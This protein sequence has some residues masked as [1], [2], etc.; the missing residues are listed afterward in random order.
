MIKRCLYI[1]T[2]L[3]LASCASLRH[4][5][6][7][8]PKDVESKN[9][10]KEISTEKQPE[11]KEI[12]IVAPSVSKAELEAKPEVP[13]KPETKK[14]PTKKTRK[15]EV[16]APP[17]ELKKIA[18]PFSVGEIFKMDLYFIGIKAAT[19]T[20]E[21]KPF[22]EINGKKM[23]HFTGIAETSSLMAL[24]YKVYNVIDTYVDYDTFVPVKMTLTM[25]ESK[26]NVSMVLNYDHKD[27]KS[28]FW[29][30]R[31]DKDKNITEINRVDD[32]TPMAQDMFS[33]LYYVRMLPLKV[34]E[35]YKF[36]IHDNGK[37]WTLIIDVVKEEK[38]WTRL[39]AVDTLLLHPTAERD[40]E[41]FTKGSMY[42]WVTNDEKKIPVKFEAE[43]RIGSMKG[44]IKD[45]IKGQE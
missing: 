34:G 17:Q 32:L 14:G 22:V 2:L 41:K 27:G 11:L 8:V 24:I 33:S 45:Y 25:D 30:K 7:A 20:V 36:V 12:T 23:F 18:A 10:V 39:G 13:A 4:G 44:I 26:Q 6:I 5:N 3:A 19:L 9:Q 1:V 31:I 35:K 29:K 28:H 42:L 40:G 43:V 37:N 38:V 15:K 16:A 21:V